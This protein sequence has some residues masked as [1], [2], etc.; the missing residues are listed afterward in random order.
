MLW[1]PVE[2]AEKYVSHIQLATDENVQMGKE[3]MAMT[4][5]KNEEASTVVN[6]VKDEAFKPMT[7]VPRRVGC[8][9]VCCLKQERE[10][11]RR[12]DRRR[13]RRKR[14]PARW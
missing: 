2:N 13:G 5:D 10:W 12:P 6:C 7:L 9:R 3:Q 11:R 1:S 8:C 14:R 4:L